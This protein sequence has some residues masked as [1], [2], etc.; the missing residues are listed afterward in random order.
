MISPVS[1]SFATP[2]TMQKV[3]RTRKIA[4]VAIGISHHRN[5]P[6]SALQEAYSGPLPH[7]KKTPTVISTYLPTYIPTCKNISA[8]RLKNRAQVLD[9]H[10][11][12]MKKMEI[13][14]YLFWT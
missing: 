10:V 9:W 11:E 13:A 8:K 3:K 4:A 5:R 12:P 6:N 1:V 2:K 14:S 7:A